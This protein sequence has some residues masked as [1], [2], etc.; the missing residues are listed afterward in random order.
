MAYLNGIPK[1]GFGTAFDIGD[2]EGKMTAQNF[3]ELLERAIKLGCCHIDCAPLYG[4]QQLVGQV[5]K[6]VA[7]S[8]P[9][10]KI[11]ITSKLPVN[12][13]RAEN[14]DKCIRNT[15]NELQTTYLDLF[16]IHAPFS[17]QFVAD[18]LIYP[19]D[20]EGNLLLDETEGLL[21]SA[22]LKLVD[23]KQNGFVRYIG[24]SNINIEQLNRFNKIHQID[25]VQNEYHLYNQDREIFDQ[26]E[27]LDVHYEAYAAF[28]CPPRAKLEDKPTF[29]TDPVVTRIGQANGMSNA[30][31]MIQWLH[32]QPLSYVVRT[33]NIS[34][35]E[36]NL[37]ATT[38]KS[39]NLSLSMNDMIELDYLNK[40]LR[41]YLFDNYKG[42]ARHKEYPFKKIQSS[43][44]EPLSEYREPRN[45]SP[46]VTTQSQ[47]HLTSSPREAGGSNRAHNEQMT[48]NK[49]Y[50]ESAATTAGERND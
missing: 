45:E 33:D 19:L 23:L 4:T 37:Y 30:Q 5:V 27:E 31:V 9:R 2:G 20:G 10:S 50:S 22:W 41:L 49:D 47:E 15:L 6:K 38:M 21:E 14:I 11:F 12:M 7:D 17:T 42:I 34:Q 3:K 39:R 35:L 18:N 46:S 1:Y 29:L 16:L 8:V 48:P 44:R 13:M 28:G 36:E 26:C 40:N 25:V 24:F 32:Q 43:Q